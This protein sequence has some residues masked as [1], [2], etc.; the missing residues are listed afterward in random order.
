MEFGIVGSQLVARYN[1]DFM[2]VQDSTFK[3]GSAYLSGKDDLRDI[4]FINLDGLPEAEALR[5]LGV[6]EQGND[7]RGKTGAAK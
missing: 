2:R 1:D 4:E 7:L 3:Q 6:D 5:L